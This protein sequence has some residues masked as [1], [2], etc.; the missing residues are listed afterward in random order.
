M[1]G[2]KIDREQYYRERSLADTDK[3]PGKDPE[4]VSV[5]LALIHTY[6]VAERRL[7]RDLQP[8]GLSPSAFNLLMILRHHCDNGCAM[9]V[10]S[11]LMLVSRANVTGLVDLLE[12]RGLVQRSCSEKD[13][14][15]RTIRITTEGL[16]LLDELLPTHYQ[17]INTA[18]KSLSSEERK[19]AVNLLSKLRAGLEFEDTEVKA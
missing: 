6:D 7:I 12:D 11:E 3:F 5:M 13:K 1:G 10:A 16:R 2:G 18:M 17:F 14:R 19:E 4:A 15:S 9:S 8:W